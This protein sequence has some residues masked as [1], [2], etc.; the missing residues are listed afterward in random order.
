VAAYGLA[1]ALAFEETAQRALRV[2]GPQRA[3][4]LAEVLKIACRGKG[5]MVP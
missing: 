5:E 2:L 4:V 1:A 3:D